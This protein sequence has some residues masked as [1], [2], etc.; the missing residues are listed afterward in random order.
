MQSRST[1]KDFDIS[2]IALVGLVL[3]T[4]A[5]LAPAAARADQLVV[6]LDGYAIGV[7]DSSGSDSASAPQRSPLPSGLPTALRLPLAAAA[8]GTV[9]I[10]LRQENLDGSVA[11][12]GA[13]PVARLRIL[14]PADG[15]V[16]ENGRYEATVGMSATFAIDN[17]LTGKS[18]VFDVKLGGDVESRS[19]YGDEFQISIEG[20][21][22]GEDGKPVDSPTKEN[23]SFW[24][25]LPGHFEQ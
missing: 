19:A 4:G 7:S 9:T 3:L 20:W 6:R 18:K 8:D 24:G 11:N 21:R 23:R 10:L 15:T 1:T 5:I 16:T 25:T 22:R 13:P 17:L 12:G 14:S 2:R